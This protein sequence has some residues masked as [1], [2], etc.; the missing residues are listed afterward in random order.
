MLTKKEL[1]TIIAGYKKFIRPNYY[2]AAS[3]LSKELKVAKSKGKYDDLVRHIVKGWDDKKFS[4]QYR[5]TKKSMEKA[6][7]AMNGFNWNMNPVSMNFESLYQDVE[8]R[9]KGIPFCQ[10]HLTI[11]D[12]TKR[13]GLLYG[14]EPQSSVYLHRG[15]MVGAKRL[16]GKNKLPHTLL[17]TDFPSPLCNESSIFIE[18]ILCVFKDTFLPISDK[19]HVKANTIL[20]R[21]PSCNNP[22]SPRPK[23]DCC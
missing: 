11:Y 9:M 12:I 18:D 15:A 13:I 5:M 2:D 6:V 14:I 21:N 16:L 23:T 17:R 10:G 8:R 22:K 1:T 20:G 19:N 7:I 4:H 3:R